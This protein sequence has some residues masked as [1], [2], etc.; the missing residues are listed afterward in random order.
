VSELQNHCFGL[1]RKVLLR[2]IL[3]RIGAKTGSE[4][5]D[6]QA[7]FR[8]GKGARDQITN[9]RIIMS[10]AQEHQQPLF[11]CFVDFRKAFDSV[12]QIPQVTFNVGNNVITSSSVVR[13]LGIYLDST[14]TMTT[15][16][17]RT[18]SNCFAALRQVRSVRRSPM[19]VMSSLITALVLT[20]LD[21]GNA[22][23]AGLP[24]MPAEPSAVRSSRSYTVSLWGPEASAPGT[25]HWLSVP[26]RI[27]FKLATLVFRCM[28]GL[29][30]AYLAATLNRAADVDSRRRL[31]SGSS[32]ALLVPMT[33][34][35]TLGNRAF[36]V[37]AGQVWNRLPATL[38]SQSSPL[39]FRQ[40]LKTFLFKQ[41][42]S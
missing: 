31:R 25:L 37:A 16:I 39:T 7:G 34:R 10:K 18:V 20:R 4:L 14:L 13:D 30:Q 11:L 21:C 35:R 3:E 33:R 38:T 27:T 9:L 24:T 28:H 22:I 42:Y 19:R 29:A 6:E 41:S 1:Q 2:V 26:D 40:Q 12:Q 8:K 32:A 5:S 23:L 15:H 17:S 36:P